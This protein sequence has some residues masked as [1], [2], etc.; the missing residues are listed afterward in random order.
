[1]RTGPAPG[2]RAGER[3]REALAGWAIPEE[4]VRSAPESPWGFSV[5]LF[6]SR[7]DEAV[8]NLTRSNE[9]AVEAL[10]EG[11]SVLDVGCGA[12]A[13]S[14]PLAAPASRL[15]GV[16]TSPEMLE[17]FLERARAAGVAAEAIEGRWPDAAGRAPVVDVAVCHH[18]VYNAPDL[19][20]F[21]VRLTDHARRR[22][23]V[24]MTTEHPLAP[25]NELWLRFHGVVR[26]TRPTADD[27]VQVLAEAGLD[28]EREDWTAPRPG[29]FASREDL[30]ASVRRQLCLPA[31]RDPEVEE[32]IAHRIV[33]RHGRFGFPD[34]PV[35]TIWWDG[36]G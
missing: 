20:E 23:V 16:D 1:M 34:R 32:A 25:M 13:A 10:P 35:A 5:E 4:I 28:P 19:R 21:A 15:V 33:E 9:R 31:G 3:W 7:A 11:G 2:A 24:E 27:A 26:P 36:R 29:G 30:V 12:G 6:A 17:A 22:V 8:R 18:V 14:L